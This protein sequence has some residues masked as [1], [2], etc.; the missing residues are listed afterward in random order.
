MQVSASPLGE[1]IRDAGDLLG[2]V[3]PHAPVGTPQP[4]ADVSSS[5]LYSLLAVLGVAAVFV[6]WSLR[7]AW[8]RQRRF[9][10]GLFP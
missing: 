8:R 6:A 7:P 4:S 3:A 1:A 2:T 5:V 10:N 9:G